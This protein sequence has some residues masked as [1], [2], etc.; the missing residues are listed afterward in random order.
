ME[1]HSCEINTSLLW[2]IEQL[3]EAGDSDFVEMQIRRMGTFLHE[4]SFITH[5]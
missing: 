5:A 2:P 4:A 3:Q 1:V